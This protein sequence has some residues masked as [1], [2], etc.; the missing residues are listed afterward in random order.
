MEWKRDCHGSSEDFTHASPLSPELMAKF[1]LLLFM[2][3]DAD[4]PGYSF[5]LDVFWGETA[6]SGIQLPQDEPVSAA[7]S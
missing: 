6:R 2:A 3:A 1:E 4:R 7:A 5:T